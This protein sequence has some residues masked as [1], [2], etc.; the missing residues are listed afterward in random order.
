MEGR[1]PGG[2]GSICIRVLGSRKGNL[3]TRHDYGVVQKNQAGSARW[4]GWSGGTDRAPGL[5]PAAPPP[6]LRSA[7]GCRLPPPQPQWLGQNLASC[8]SLNLGSR[9]NA[10]S[11]VSLPHPL[12]CPHPPCC[13]PLPCPSSLGEVGGMGTD[14]EIR[15]SHYFF[16]SVATGQCPLWSLNYMPRRKEDSIH[17]PGTLGREESTGELCCAHF[18]EFL[19]D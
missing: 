16:L 8:V 2:G 4:R 10:A 11:C 1:L 19:V 6:P 17:L 13:P 15:V 18:T 5:W 14:W 12:A 9:N 3:G 7:P